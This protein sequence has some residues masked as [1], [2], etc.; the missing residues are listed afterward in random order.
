[1]A[2]EFK[3]RSVEEMRSQLIRLNCL[4]VVLGTFFDVMRL[5]PV[6]ISE[7]PILEI[8]ADEIAELTVQTNGSAYRNY[9]SVSKHPIQRVVAYVGGINS[10]RDILII[11]K[12]IS[13]ETGNLGLPAGLSLQDLI[14]YRTIE[15]I[16]RK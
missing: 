15:E 1:M 11:G 3:S 16:T 2:F 9:Q 10:S 12:D 5:E 14:G 6:R 8:R 4:D 13:P 7:D